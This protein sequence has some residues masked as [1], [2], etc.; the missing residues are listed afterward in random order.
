MNEN[1]NNQKVII[2]CLTL[3]KAEYPK[4][5]YEDLY[6]LDVLINDKISS[7]HSSIKFNKF[8]NTYIIDLEISF[9]EQLDIILFK[10]CSEANN[11]PL[12]QPPKK[13]VFGLQDKFFEF[14]DMAGKFFRWDRD[15]N[16]FK[17]SVYLGP[18]PNSNKKAV[19]ENWK[20]YRNKDIEINEERIIKE[21]FYGEDYD[22]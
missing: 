1:N 2:N 9:Q 20:K 14:L 16:S 13:L 12:Y 17:M 3:K 15:L 19:I 22:E 4:E 7:K 6:Y 10:L 18:S 8:D 21:Y 11:I 5:L